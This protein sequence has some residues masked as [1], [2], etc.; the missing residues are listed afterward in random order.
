LNV[1]LFFNNHSIFW[2]N[3]TSLELSKY[4]I[5]R[6]DIMSENNTKPDDLVFLYYAQAYYYRR[7]DFEVDIE[8]KEIEETEEIEMNTILRETLENKLKDFAQDFIFAP[9][10]EFLTYMG[11]TY[12]KVL[13]TLQKKYKNILFYVPSIGPT[14]T[15]KKQTISI[16]FILLIDF[17]H[18]DE[19]F[20]KLSQEIVAKTALDKYGHFEVNYNNK[21]LTTRE[22][23][24]LAIIEN[25]KNMLRETF[26]AYG[27][28]INQIDLDKIYNEGNFNF[29]FP[30]TNTMNKP[31]DN[32]DDNGDMTIL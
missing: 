8:K 11:I 14:S 23:A 21:I 1:V 2:Y 22:T 6:R 10:M 27:L 4:K 13:M 3:K 17:E 5:L 16:N 12:N 32:D 7:D 15:E 29:G 30:P 25:K 20:W 24:E 18:G 19:G 28:D 31:D 26:E 9:E